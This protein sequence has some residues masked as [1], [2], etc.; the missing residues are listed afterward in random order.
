MPVILNS[1]DYEKWLNGNG[2]EVLKKSG[3]QNDL[4]LQ[5]YKVAPEVGNINNDSRELLKE[6]YPSQ[7]ALF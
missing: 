4:D 6:Y 5:F 1:G 2:L 3:T 7:L